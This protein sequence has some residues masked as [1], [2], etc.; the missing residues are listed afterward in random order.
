MDPPL[1][2]THNPNHVTIFTIFYL[3]EK[4]LMSVQNKCLNILR[5]KTVVKPDYKYPCV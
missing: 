5:I 3:H 1:I 4:S 2:S